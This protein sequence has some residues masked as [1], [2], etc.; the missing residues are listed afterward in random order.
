MPIKIP[1]DLPAATVLQREQVFVM[2]EERAIHQDIRPLRLLFLNLMPKKIDTEIQYM[3]KLSNTPLQVDIELLRIDNHVSRNTPQEHLDRFYKNFD[4]VQGKFYDGM[5]VTG[6]PLDQIRFENVT[7]WNRIET[8]LRWSRRHVT[9]TLFSCWAAAAA[10]KVFYDLPMINVPHKIFGVFTNSI[11]PSSNPLIRGFDDRFLV[12]QS[13]F[14]AFPSDVLRTKTDLQILAQSAQAGVFLAVSPDRK[15]VYVTG[16][17]EYDADTLAQE[18]ERDRERGKN[19]ALPVHYF[20]Q[21]DP[22]QTPKCVWRSHASL[23]FSNWLN[24]YVYQ[25]TPYTLPP[26]EEAPRAA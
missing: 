11:E 24:Y 5:I 3:R 9:S 6:A 22:H 26:D 8:M 21:D 4:E 2:T 17:P 12:P 13:R 19:P 25:T 10:L 20:P 7:Y 18:Y 16:H 15:Q 1:N 14:I 23:L